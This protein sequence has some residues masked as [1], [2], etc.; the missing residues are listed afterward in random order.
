[1]RAVD[2]DALLGAR[3]LAAGREQAAQAT[4]GAP[5]ALGFERA[6]AAE[7]TLVPAHHPTKAGLQRRDAGPELV[8]VEREA[9]LEPQRVAR[10]QTGRGHARGQHGSPER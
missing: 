4:S 6:P 3:W 9:G 10:A 5:L 1:V 8:A 2:V 7:V